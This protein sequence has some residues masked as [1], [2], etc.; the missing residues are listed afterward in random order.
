MARSCGIR[1]GPRRFELVVLDGSARKHRL[2]AF[3]TGEFGTGADPVRESVAALKE[4]VKAHNVPSDNTSIAIDSGL[5]AFRTL[6]LP[7]LDET[8]IEEVLKFE[9]ESE[10]PQWSIDDVVVDF[11]TLEQTESESSLM[12]TAVPKSDVARA[13]DLC[14]DA[15]VEPQEV[16]L[17]ATA[18]VN[19]ALSADICHVDDAQVL[20]H[21]GEHSSAVVVM[22]GG[23]VRSIRA[24]HIGAMTH[25]PAPAAPSEEEEGEGEGEVVAE[26]VDLEQ[27]QEDSER[28]LEQ[29]V[30]RIRR[31]LGRTLSAART[32]NPIDAIYVCGWELPNLIETSMLDIPVY[33]LDVFEEDSGQPAEGAAPLVIA[34]GV[35]LRQ[36]GGGFIQ[37]RLRREELRFTGAFE[38]VELPLAVASLMLVTLLGVFVIFELKQVKLR[39]QDVNLWL[40]SAVNFMYGEPK[41]NKPGNLDRS[42]KE[43]DEYTDKVR[44]APELLEHNRLEQ[45]HQVHRL[46]GLEIDRLDKDLGNTGEVTQPQS[47]L[48]ALALVIGVI[49]DLGDEVGRVAV[50][51]AQA[52]TRHGSLGA[53]EN[54]EVRLDLSFFADNAGRA[55]GNYER[56]KSALSDTSWAV[57]VVARGTTE[58][59]EGEG[60]FTDDMR[61]TCDLSLLQ[62]AGQP[63][64]AAVGDGR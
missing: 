3:M 12:V 56:F 53:K 33:E 46:I 23:H 34:Y 25:E 10:L 55:T 40:Q 9:V 26:E 18:M 31:E 45:L 29:A 62:P 39:K 13:I 1:I 8:K 49:E 4:A 37:S 14:A 59:D 28:R 48:E 52:Q 51:K 36:L 24:I 11:L 21:I 63:A 57:D 60:I 20:V 58:F 6:K 27:E 16:E 15:G 64:V 47:S 50:R 43:L 44:N 7:A 19:A 54:V 30:S 61:I 5:A 2:T 38:R 35:A 32:T 41:D 42:W 22:D 17:E